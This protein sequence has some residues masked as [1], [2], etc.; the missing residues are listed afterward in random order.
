MA[1]PIVI[2][3]LGDA[4]D[5]TRSLGTA[6]GKVSRFGKAA[7]V[8]G[9]VA[10]GALAAGVGLAGTALVKGF[11]RLQG[12]D[13]AK[14]KLTG[15]GHS[16]KGVSKIMQNATDAVTGTA[17][18]LDAAAGVA[19][20]TVAA[21]VKPGKDLERTLKLVGD[22]ATGRLVRAEASGQA[23]AA[24]ALGGEVAAMLLARGA[25]E[26]LPSPAIT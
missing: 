8:A 22:A 13:Q 4:R 14:S 21:G 3:I 10:G 16:A 2:S 1:S 24:G 11:N 25:G 15:L 6:E 7:K 26:L 12:I 5:L 17:F 18:G 19:A 20:S 23:H 9:R